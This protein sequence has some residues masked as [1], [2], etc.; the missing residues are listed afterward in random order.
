MQPLDRDAVRGDLVTILSEVREDW[1]Y[2]DEITEQTGIFK[3]LGYESIDAVVLGSAIEEHFDQ[4]LPFA[5]FLTKSN[6]QQAKEITIGNLLDFLMA[7][8]KQP[9]IRRHRSN[10]GQV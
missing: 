2:T 1:E 3:D 9:A 7:H 6:E 4:S 10:E 8:L 5:E